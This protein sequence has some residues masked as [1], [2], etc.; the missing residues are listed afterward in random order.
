MIQVLSTYITPLIV[1]SSEMSLLLT[2]LYVEYVHQAGDLYSMTI[3]VPRPNAWEDPSSCL[4]IWSESSCISSASTIDPAF[5]AKSSPWGYV[6][7]LLYW[8][9]HQYCV[10]KT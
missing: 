1:L 9:W 5:R 10:G 2:R 4:V 3:Q 8:P 7:K 6:A